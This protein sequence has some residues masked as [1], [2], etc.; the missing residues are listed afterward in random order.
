MFLGGHDTVANPY[1]VRTALEVFARDAAAHGEINRLTVEWRDDW[2][3]G[4]LHDDAD[5]QKRVLKEWL[6]RW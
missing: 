1:N 5:E 4:G 6:T 3:H 2:Y